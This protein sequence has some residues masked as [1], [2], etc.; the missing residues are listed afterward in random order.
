MNQSKALWGLTSSSARPCGTRASAPR[1][2]DIGVRRH[3]DA[4]HNIAD[5]AIAPL[6][7]Y[8]PIS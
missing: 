3:M 5:A 2:A 1:F 8:I 4:T 6:I 7:V